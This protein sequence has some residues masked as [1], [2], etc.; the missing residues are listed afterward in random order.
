[1]PPPMPDERI[2]VPYND[3][4]KHA[5]DVFETV[6]RQILADPAKREEVRR[7]LN[8]ASQSAGAE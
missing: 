2:T 4:T 8:I 6:A 5:Y 7:R 3:S 1:M